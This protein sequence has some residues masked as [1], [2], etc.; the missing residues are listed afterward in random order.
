[1]NYRM[2]RAGLALIGLVVVS[3]CGMTT[4]TAERFARDIEFAHGAGSWRAHEALSADIVVTFMG[5]TMLE[6]R[7]TFTTDM[8]R[9][10]IETTAGPVMVFDGERAWLSPASA[11]VEMARFHLL[12]WP[13]F[14]AAPYKLQDPGSHLSY[15]GTMPL[16]DSGTEY[17]VAELTFDAGVG[18]TPDDWYVCYRDL[19]TG[20]LYSMAYIITYYQDTAKANAE[21]HAI[22]YHDFENLRGAMI[23]TTWKFWH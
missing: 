15:L 5:G 11:E 3:G 23:S 13:Y 6:G 2:M 1:M 18:D 10:R 14:V 12:T 19:A 4:T 21:P 16:D 7:M 20:R 9:A 22:T 17:D 8:S